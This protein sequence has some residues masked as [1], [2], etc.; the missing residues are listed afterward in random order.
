M[1]QMVSMRLSTELV[2]KLEHAAKARGWNRSELIRRV[3][4]AWCDQQSGV[5][6]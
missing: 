3:L 6:S 2:E 1:E 4:D 5:R